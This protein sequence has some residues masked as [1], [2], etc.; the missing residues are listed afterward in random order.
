MITLSL[1]MIVKN[2]EDTLAR[3]LDSIKDAVD[4]II[5]ADTGSTDSTVKIA[6]R[7]TDKVYHFDWVYDFSAA[8]NF[9]FSKASSDYCMWLDADDII[10]ENDLLLLK[11]LKKELS[12]DTDI[13]MMPYNTSFD[14]FGNVIFSYY[15]ERI[16]KNNP[17]Y[18]WSGKVHE[19]ITPI[20]NVI[21]YDAAVTHKKEK[22]PDTDRNLKIY[23]KMLE[24]KEFFSPRDKFYYARELYY[25]KRFD[26]AISAFTDFLSEKSAWIENKID[27][28]LILADCYIEKK[29]S[30]SAI[31]ALSESLTF[32]APRAEIC[33]KIGEIMLDNKNYLG[34][35]FWFKSALNSDEHKK[36][37]GF[38][39]PDC[40][41]FL[42]AIWLSVCYDRLSEYKKACEYNNLALSFKPQSEAALSNKRYFESIG[43]K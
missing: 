19:A 1:C 32:D 25:H 15:R 5:I 17:A 14:K 8:R 3:C 39:L 12:T 43:Y 31:S 4:E 20:G 13:V 16:I 36:S 18:K 21:Y 41:G 28:C 11:K 2:E 22:A 23:E 38:S 33:C 26:E 34:A 40:R 42:P 6:K 29:D 24:K 9:S 30:V 27:A 10:D 37:G 35:I 7:Y